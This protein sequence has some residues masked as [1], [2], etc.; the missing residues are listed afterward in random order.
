M[1]RFVISTFRSLWAM[2]QS[3]FKKPDVTGS[4]QPDPARRLVLAGAVAIVVTGLIGGL[5]S[6]TAEARHY[7]GRSRRRHLY[8]RSRRRRHLYRRSRRRHLYR[9]SRRRHY[10]GRSRRRHSYR[11]SRRRSRRRHY[12]RRSWY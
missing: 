1:K 3:I 5:G 12:Y 2:L 7:Y 10:Y 11:R 4:D 9:R 6:S 8:R